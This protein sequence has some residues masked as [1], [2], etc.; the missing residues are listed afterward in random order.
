MN[1]TKLVFFLI[2]LLLLFGLGI[3]A[4]QALSIDGAEQPPFA[5][6]VG[7]EVGVEPPASPPAAPAVLVEAAAQP[8]AFG[9]PAA[10]RVDERV[11]VET[12]PGE[13]RTVEG[14]LVLP[15]GAAH[16]NTLSVVA[17][18]ASLVE[19]LQPGTPWPGDRTWDQHEVLA[20]AQVE[21]DGA[22]RLE[23]PAAVL[24]A[25]GTEVRFDV[26]GR[27]LYLSEPVAFDSTSSAAV[28]LEPE[29]G[30]A[31]RGRLKLPRGTSEKP[32]SVR[33]GGLGMS[34]FGG[35][36]SRV[37]KVDE[38][39]EF[40]LRALQPGLK[41]MLSAAPDIYPCTTLEEGVTVEAGRVVDTRIE[42]TRGATVRGQ[43]VDTE[44]APLADVEV[45]GDPGSSF[46]SNPAAGRART[47]EDGRFELRG[48][49]GREQVLNAQ[50]EEFLD[51]ESEA[52]AL[53]EGKT[54]E[55]V[56][57]VL[58][59]G[60]ELSGTIHWPDGEAAVG[61]RLTVLPVDPSGS[62]WR[63]F[64][65]ARSEDGS[66]RTA[67][68]G[69]F[70]VG[71][72]IPGAYGLFAE[73]APRDGAPESAPWT[74]RLESVEAGST[75]LALTLAA[76]VTY[77]GSAVDD[78]GVAVDTFLVSAERANWP[79]WVDG[80]S[81]TV[82]ETF[83]DAAG[84]FELDGLD[85]GEWTIH[86]RAHG[87][88]RTEDRQVVVPGVDAEPFTLVRT[89][90]IEGVVLDPNGL[91]VAGAE[92]H[93]IAHATRGHTGVE[94]TDEEGRYVLESVGPGPIALRARSEDWA[95]SL[96][97]TFDVT[98]GEQRDPWTL[99]LTQG[100]KL[101]GIVFDSDGSPDAERTI[102][103]QSTEGGEYYEAISDAG[104]RFVAE[105]VAPG[106]YQVIAT[107]DYEALA[108]SGSDGDPDLGDLFAEMRMTM[109]TVVADETIEIVL[110]APPRAPV[111][112]H[113]RVLRG[114]EPVPR[115][116][117]LVLA[118]SGSLLESMRADS[119]GDDG[120][121]EV[122]VDEPGD[123]TFV[124][125][126]SFH[127]GNQV[128]FQVSLPEVERYELDLVL[129]EGSITGH[130]RHADGSIPEAGSM[131]IRREDGIS[132]LSNLM[133]QSIGPLEDGGRF[134]ITTLHPGTYAITAVGGG[135]GMTTVHGVVVSADGSAPEVELVLPEAGTIEG[136][137]VDETGAG[138][139]DATVFLRDG[140][141]RTLFEL[142]DTTDRDG[143]FK[144][145]YVPAGDVFVCA[146]TA[147]SVALE[148]YS[149]RVVAGEETSVDVTLGHGVQLRVALED[150]DGEPMRAAI[151]VENEAGHD[152][153]GS[154]GT[155]DLEDVAA[156]G[157]SS[158]ERR[159][160]PL[161]PGRYTLRA[162][163][164]DGRSAKKTVTL[165]ED[166]G[167]RTVR[168]RLKD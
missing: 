64:E 57:I 32:S 86:V 18:G 61:A 96:E 75:D 166:A 138:V 159:V 141:G 95:P 22:F 73:L 100:A 116:G 80:S 117:V 135:S 98:S 139:H 143:A 36:M 10:S 91:P 55:D 133:S 83:P 165:R 125:M 6:S 132:D 9:A 167:E 119:A 158:T 62:S 14:R 156:R 94:E 110:G 41:F 25:E 102:A 147:D 103:I 16:E 58:D 109:V 99:H 148:S 43:V 154:S 33:V 34:N 11:A 161:R 130:V 87:H 101:E 71:G 152:F 90:R 27:F 112:V 17:L 151:R 49:V 106:S 63:L 20:R 149:A 113:G 3:V 126:A 46:T 69:S 74:V 68:D 29:L 72:L 39:L 5:Y 123:Y 168:L 51:G 4:A 150:E 136:T 85:A 127:D 97:D 163:S 38:T 145:G 15:R 124:I 84:R 53:A 142:E 120:T 79:T 2:A 114:G 56:S 108:A 8:V 54:I 24:D 30:G 131:W 66:G 37:V 115:A 50:H 89:A 7:E 45:W 122:K 76:P 93:A 153:A 82:E 88:L 19:N 164:P 107:P 28:V 35:G 1:H 12:E 52:L 144:I 111:L 155:E 77:S 118:E 47:D 67:R 105:H 48:L 13:V 23:L 92:V 157:V 44:G 59:A 134:E 78:A 146:H 104:G 40:E 26:D 31:I 60:L 140:D 65:K 137:V 21:K 128:D 70:L 160:G 162:T 129:P 121:F 42:L 81:K